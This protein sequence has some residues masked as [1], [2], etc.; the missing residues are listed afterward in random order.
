[1]TDEICTLI[2]KT[3]IGK[4]SR[5]QVIYEEKRTEVLCTSVPISRA[6]FFSAG[7]I[8]ITPDYE[9]IINPIEYDGQ[10]VV[11]YKGKRLEIY[12]IYE[13]NENELE[14]YAHWVP[15]LSGGGQ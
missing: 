4:N 8:G 13:R 7:Q 6:E 2:A 9:L 14:I 5:M 3:A 11:E 15:G 1:M 10:K 12:R